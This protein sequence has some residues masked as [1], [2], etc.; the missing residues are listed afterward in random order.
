MI[1]LLGTQRFR[2]EFSNHIASVAKTIL[3]CHGQLLET[4]LIEDMQNLKNTVVTE[5]G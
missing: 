1:D 3:H 5:A 4:R 2:S